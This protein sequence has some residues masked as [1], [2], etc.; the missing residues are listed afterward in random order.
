[1]L[2]RPTK[3]N[4][5]TVIK[6]LSYL[7]GCYDEIP[8]MEGLAN[9]LNVAVSTLYEWAN[10]PD[11]RT[12]SEALNKIKQTQGDMLIQKGLKGDYNATIAKLMLHNHGYSDKQSTELTGRDGGSIEMDHYLEIS[13]VDP[14]E[15]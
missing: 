9:Y 10:D 8:T 12:F 5:E 6:A 14:H 2:G 7:E 15:D 1:M 11:K 4:D 3:Y 13:I